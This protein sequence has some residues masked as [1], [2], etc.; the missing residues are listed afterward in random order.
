MGIQGHRCEVNLAEMTESMM[1]LKAT[2]DMQ[3]YFLDVGGRE[4]FEA[5]L[6]PLL[7][8]VIEG[9]LASVLHGKTL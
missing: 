7:Y 2:S 5:V 3:C 6:S 1:Y 9:L 8:Q 4:R